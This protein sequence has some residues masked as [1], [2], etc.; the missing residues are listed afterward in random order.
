MEK[1]GVTQ[2][3][4]TKNL[5]TSD[6]QVYTVWPGTVIASE[7]TKQRVENGDKVGIKYLGMKKNYKDF[8]VL[9]EKRKPDL[10]EDS[11]RN[12]EEN[13]DPDFERDD[14]IGEPG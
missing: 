8:V 11:P 1:T 2:K 4:S 10:V 9:V 6:G 14:S 5:T 12:G 7:L 3:V 13:R